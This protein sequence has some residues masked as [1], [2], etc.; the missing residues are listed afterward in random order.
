MNKTLRLFFLLLLVLFS[1]TFVTQIAVSQD[2]NLTAKKIISGLDWPTAITFS[3]DRRIFVAERLSGKILV[4]KNNKLDGKPFFEKKV[5]NLFTY[6][7]TGLLGLAIHPMKPYLYAYYTYTDSEG[8]LKNSVIRI[9]ITN[10]KGAFDKTIIDNIPGNNIHVGGIVTFG[11]DNKLYI[12]TGDSG[13]EEL[14][15]NVDSLAGKILRLNDD[16]SIPSDNPFKNSPVYS[17]GH[18]NVFGIAFSPT[19]G[20]LV[21][22]ENGPQT[23]DEINIVDKGKNYGWPIT[24]G[25]ARQKNYVDPVLTYTPNISPTNVAFYRGNN[26]PSEFKNSAFFGDWNNGD[27]HNI[28]F[29]SKDK[30]TE[31]VVLN[32]E[33]GIIDVEASPEGNIYFTTENSIYLLESKL[34]AGKKASR[35]KKTDKIAFSIDLKLALIIIAGLILLNILLFT[36]LNRQFKKLSKK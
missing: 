15:Q 19:D 29:T 22:T 11:P 26:L 36:F 23:D 12:S 10:G 34:Q 25:K 27:L 3:P 1:L 30:V 7:E 32:T 16:G 24:L 9:K 5:P 4:L 21:I 20:G 2:D 35:Q 6:H 13:N 31:K 8:N 28:R 33:D 14:S 17:L 18:R